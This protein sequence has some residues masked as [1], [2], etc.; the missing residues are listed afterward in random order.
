MHFSKW[1]GLGNDFIVLDRRLG[2]RWPTPAQVAHLCDRHFGIGADGVLLITADPR[3]EAGMVV[4]NADG[5]SPEMCGN[6]LRCVA[7]ALAARGELGPA[8]ATGAGVLPVERHGADFRIEMGA[9]RVDAVRR[10]EWGGAVFDGHPVCT[11]N[12]HFVLYRDTPWTDVEIARVGPG[13]STHPSFPQGVNVS[14]AHASGRDR[15][16]L[17]VWERGAGLTLACGTGA[18]AAVAAG[19]AAGHLKGEVEVQ[20]P[21]GRLR[22]GHSAQTE[23]TAQGGGNSSEVWMQGPARHVFDGRLPAGWA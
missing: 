1:Q 22:V 13:L 5:S 6:G 14:F 15:L 9:A 19:W 23:A 4:F 11:G 16:D 21:G 17:V 3:A 12:P 7:G 20:L 10:V 8:I 18:C 2:G